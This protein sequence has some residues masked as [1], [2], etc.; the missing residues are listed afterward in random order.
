MP[1]PYK[2]ADHWTKKAKAEGFA[3]RSVFKL[4]EIHARFPLLGGH[5]AVDLG[6]FPGSW[7]QWLVQRGVRVVGVDLKQPALPGTWI[8]RSVLD[9]TAEELLEASAGPV[10]LLVSDMAPN[11]TGNRFSDHCMQ[12]ELAR[13]ALALAAAVLKPGG[14]FVAKVFE[15]ED[16]PAFVSEV[17][18]HFRAFKR[19]KPEATRDRSVEFFV[20]G[21]GLK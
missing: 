17:Q 16:A 20:A 19:L 5:T 18:A 8:V 10:D 15:G 6:C 13:R 11:T 9:V 7:S 2:R 21:R 4:D 12:V 1:Q 14:A 3:A